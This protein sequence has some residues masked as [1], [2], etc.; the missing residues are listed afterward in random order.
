[1]KT[2]TKLIYSAALLIS[3]AIGVVTANGAP[4][5]LFAS[6]NGSYV[7]GAGS[8]YQYRPTGQQRIFASNLSQPRGVAFDHFGNLFV[9]NNTCD[10]M[11]CQLTIVKITT[12][13]V[14]STLC[15]TQ[16]RSLWR[17]SGI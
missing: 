6:V 15:H 14:Q 17:R 3:L 1:M 2:I 8:I 13:R 10:Q 16:R 11:A 7:N 5:D 4:G 12:R 9:T